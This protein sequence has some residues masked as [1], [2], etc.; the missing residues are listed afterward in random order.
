MTTPT[1]MTKLGRFSDILAAPKIDEIFSNPPHF[2]GVKIYW[3]N[4]KERV[5]LDN[6]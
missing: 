2:L 4:V 3:K 5:A 6:W 1:K